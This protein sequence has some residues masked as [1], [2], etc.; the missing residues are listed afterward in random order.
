MTASKKYI[1]YTGCPIKA[2]DEAIKYHGQEVA[3]I[4]IPEKLFDRLVPKEKKR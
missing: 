1:K 4:L 3:F 2:L